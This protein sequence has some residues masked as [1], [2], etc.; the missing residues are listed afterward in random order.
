MSRPREFGGKS[1]GTDVPKP[2]KRVR[3]VKFTT[4]H[5]G[6][7]LACC[8][9]GSAPP[10][11]KAAAWLT[12]LEYDAI[13]P[14]WSH[15]VS[16]FE[17]NFD[18]LRY[19]ERGCGMSDRETGQLDIDSWVDDFSR[20]ASAAR[21][22]NPFAIIAMSQGT[23]AAVRYAAENPDHVSHLVIIG[24]YARGHFHR[25]DEQAEALYQAIVDI[26]GAGFDDQNPAFREVFTKRFLP[27][28]DPEK[29][30][31]FNDLCRRSVDA[32]TGSKLLAARGDMDVSASL[33][34]VECPTLVLHARGDGV[35][36]LS[37]GRFLAQHISGAEFHVLDSVNHILQPDEPA[38][39]EA[40]EAILSFIGAS[41]PLAD[42]DL[43]PRERAI[44]DEICAAK[45]NKEI[46]RELDVSE[47]TIRNHATNIFA[48]IGVSSRQE[49]IVKVRGG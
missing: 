45:S 42:F 32:A 28:G 19:D 4:T 18:Y 40:Q 13:S 9:S 41:V 6:L 35:A 17:K 24:G 48:K 44:L 16:F 8:R 7:S 5:D 46:A 37:E 38:W 10:L 36:P 2:E 31:W 30:N 3:S 43:T 21:L 47:K 33:K 22:P 15:W 34:Q 39:N 11:I 12:H 14:L 29:I 25:G 1:H 49:A 27:E 23:G 26:F 20:V